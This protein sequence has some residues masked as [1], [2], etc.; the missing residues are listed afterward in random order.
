[1]SCIAS[2]T[3]PVVSSTPRPETIGGRLATMSTAYPTPRIVNAEGVSRGRATMC[4]IATPTTRARIRTTK[5]PSGRKTS[6]SASVIVNAAVARPM[7]GAITAIT[8]A[9]SAITVSTGPL[10]N[11]VA[12]I[13]ASPMTRPVAGAPCE[14]H[15]TP[16]RARDRVGQRARGVTLSMRAT[17]EAAISGRADPGAGGSPS[18]GVAGRPRG[19]LARRPDRRRRGRGQRVRALDE[20]DADQPSADLP[21]GA[22]GRGDVAPSCMAGVEDEDDAA[23]LRREE[24][25]G[26]RVERRIGHD[27]R[28]IRELPEACDRALRAVARRV[29]GGG[30]QAHAAGHHAQ[31]R[32]RP[33]R[34]LLGIE[35]VA[36]EQ[37]IEPER[38]G[39]GRHAIA[40]VQADQHGR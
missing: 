19:E 33:E 29:L 35:G 27:D 14:R 5:K 15:R 6:G 30:L 18:A 3:A 39:V 32:A 8:T 28:E 25:R 12:A 10:S 36:R 40:L 21:E 38:G 22:R 4:R 26:E 20:R 1:M 34:D 24:E 23:G 13:R 16:W 17:V 31:V 37:A 9:R 7:G 2:N 11:A